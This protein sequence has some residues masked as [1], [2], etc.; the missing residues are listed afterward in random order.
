MTDLLD[1]LSDISINFIYI[2][3]L[4]LYMFT[5]S[6]NMSCNVLDIICI[7]RVVALSNVVIDLLRQIAG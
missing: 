4:F 6:S 7:S 1:F 2:S 3:S 5:T